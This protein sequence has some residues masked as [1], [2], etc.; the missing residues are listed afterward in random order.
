QDFY[1]WKT[2][3]FYETEGVVGLRRWFEKI[4]HV[5]EISKCAE[6][7][8]VMFV[9]ITFK[10]RALTWWIENVHILGLANANGI[11]W[12]E[13]KTMMTIE[14]FLAIEIQRMEQELWTLTLKG[15][16]IEAYN[17]R[18]HKLDLMCPNLVPTK[19]KKIKRY[20]KG[21]PERIKGNITS[22]RLLTM[23]DA[24]NMARELVEQAV[25]GRASR[26]GESD[27]KK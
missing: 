23:Q 9:A 14:Y 7:D 12:S 11:P 3:S 4:E 27:K 18:F 24:I 1:E 13:F 2:S 21:F 16:D 20:I 19:K 8:K 15:D 5:F 22:L 17:N 6:G 10:R 26:I 25:Q